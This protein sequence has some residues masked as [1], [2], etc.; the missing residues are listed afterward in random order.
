MSVGGFVGEAAK[1]TSAPDT[2]LG[3]AH[4][5]FDAIGI[6]IDLAGWQ[7]ILGLASVTTDPPESAWR[8]YPLG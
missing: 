8:E 3:K 7:R 2:A 4:D 1:R 5:H 6:A